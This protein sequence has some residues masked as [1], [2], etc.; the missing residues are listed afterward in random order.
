MEL[1][2]GGKVVV[3]TG[4]S[5]DNGFAVARAFTEEEATVVAGSRS[6]SE[7]LEELAGRYPLSHVAVDLGT[8][9][10]PEK[11][12][13]PAVEQ[14]GEVDVLVNNVGMFEPRLAGFASITDEDWRRTF[15]INLMSAVR[16]SRAV[17][18]SMVEHGRAPDRRRG[19]AKEKGTPR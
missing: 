4:A 11:L 19:E 16:A 1:S 9:E 3:V 12:V 7:G 17:L 14:F 10:E 15:D 8:P 6:A 13:E 2:L 18:P 5:K